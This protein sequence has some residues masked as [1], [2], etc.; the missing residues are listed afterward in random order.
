[1]AKQTLARR[2]LHATVLGGPTT[3]LDHGG[4]RIVSDPTFDPP[5]GRGYLTKTEGP[6]QAAAQLGAVDLVLV[7]TTTIRTGE[8]RADPGG[9]RE[10]RGDRLRAVGSWPAHGVRER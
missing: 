2:E 4:L 9:L 6:A 1:M 10:L 3:V 5:G 7:A 8:R